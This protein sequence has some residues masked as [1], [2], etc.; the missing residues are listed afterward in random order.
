MILYHWFASRK[1][2]KIAQFFF[3]KIDQ[4]F[5]AKIAQNHYF[6]DF[7]TESITK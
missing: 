4:I 2:A 5:L 7:E 3:S 1:L 6:G